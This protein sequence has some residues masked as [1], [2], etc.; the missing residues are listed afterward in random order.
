MFQKQDIKLG[1]FW[2]M[3]EVLG[4]EFFAFCSFLVLTWLLAPE[5][6]GVVALATMLLMVAQL[7]LFQGIGEALVQKDGIDDA[8]FSS[9]LWMN[10]LLASVAAVMLTAA[11]SW[12]AD[13]FSEPRFAPILRAIAP[14]LL[15][16]A[17]SGILQARLRRELKLKGFALASIAATLCG[18]MVA[19]LMALMDF[20]AWSLVGRQ[21]T[22]ALISTAMFLLSA[23][24]LPKLALAREHISALAG[25]SLNTIGAALLRFGLRQVDLLFLGF[26]MPAKQVGLYFLATRIL[27][28]VG[29]LTYQ[30]IQKIGLPVLSR[31]Q[32][33]PA[34]H[35]AAVI[36][37]LRVT[38]M[39]CLPI[40]LGMA[41]TAD[42][43]IPIVFG[44]AWV[45]S[46]PPFRL[47]CL[48]SIFFALSLIANQVLLSRGHTGTMLRLSMIN[49][50]LFITAVAI[51]APHGITATA[52]AGGMAHMLC[53]PVY[54]YVLSRKLRVDLTHL[55]GELLP[56]GAAGTAMVAAV[57]AC[58]QT[59]LNTVE[60]G[61][62][63]GL[64]IILG[65]AVFTGVIASLRRDYIDEF[66]TTFIAAR[67]PHPP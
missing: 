29:Q 60:P 26:H 40:F 24:W 15:V 37:I 25:F 67:Q 46:I 45:G 23:P 56:I 39:V 21:W 16:Y 58:R 11:S 9:A 5:Q 14:L 13:A 62:N 44:P 3:V 10:M 34:K 1:I 41:M 19:A 8:F 2:R 42:L 35:Q 64:S 12:I 63:L 30:S 50:A 36:A 51:A 4:A 31:L 6:F 57:F 32:N 49:V 28:T 22:Y 53:L 66:I 52:F 7:V 38:C 61:V 48:F 18:A 54:L 55:L 43:F 59:L 27:N 20:E 33:D 17:V 47:Q 65:A